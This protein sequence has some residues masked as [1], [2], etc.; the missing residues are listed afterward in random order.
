MCVLFQITDLPRSQ[1]S[2]C[3]TCTYISIFEIELF[4]FTATLVNCL[5]AS[6]TSRWAH[7]IKVPG[8]FSFLTYLASA[9]AGSAHSFTSMAG[10]VKLPIS[11][12]TT[13]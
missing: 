4:L 9:L 6:W 3:P 10:A 1:I 8:A 2:T 7:V 13:K 12:D 5:E 11:R